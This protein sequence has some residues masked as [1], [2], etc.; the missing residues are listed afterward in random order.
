MCQEFWPSNIERLY[1]RN[2]KNQVKNVHA[3]TKSYKLYHY[4]Q[5]EGR[6]IDLVIL[7]T[8]NTF[9]LHLQIILSI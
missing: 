4:V 8:L 1:K 3:V 7:L 9:I 5:K 2:I 6:I